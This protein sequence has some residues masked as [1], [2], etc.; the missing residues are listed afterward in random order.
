[1]AKQM[2]GH[3]V[4]NKRVTQS[5]LRGHL[6]QIWHALTQYEVRPAHNRRLLNLAEPEGEQRL[7]V[8][9]INFC[10]ESKRLPSLRC[11]NSGCFQKAKWQLILIFVIATRTHETD[12]IN[13]SVWGE[14]LSGGVLKRSRQM[15]DAGQP[16][17]QGPCCP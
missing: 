11:T 12:E 7:D 17:S 15:N 5:T 8:F 16:S 2:G 9:G 3:D 1:M 14:P 10:G 13:C 4:S 6:A